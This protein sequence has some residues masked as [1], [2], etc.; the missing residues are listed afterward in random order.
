[1][2]G[3]TLVSLVVVFVLFIVHI[4]CDE[5]FLSVWAYLRPRPVVHSV[6]NE[7]LD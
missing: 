1:M 6:D 5:K 7:E 4:G 2:M 3:I